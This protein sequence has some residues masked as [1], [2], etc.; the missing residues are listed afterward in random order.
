MGPCGHVSLAYC[1]K[2]MK[3]A[4]WHM[5]Q[6]LNSQQ[7][8]CRQ[9]PA[10]NECLGTSKGMHYLLAAKV[11]VSKV[12]KSHQATGVPF[13]SRCCKNNTSGRFVSP[14]PS[15]KMFQGLDSSP[16]LLWLAALHLLRGNDSQK[17]RL[18]GQTEGQGF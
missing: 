18:L 15:P 3:A 12:I 2:S 10:Q 14:P 5:L 1:Q 8:V 9:K 11:G 7:G 16:K 6:S 4:P 13:C 17:T